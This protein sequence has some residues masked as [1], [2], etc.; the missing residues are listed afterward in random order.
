MDSRMAEQL[1]PKEL[2][3][4]ISGKSEASIEHPDINEDSIAFDE[5]AGF[6][7]VLDGMGGLNAGDEASKTARD[8]IVKRISRIREN[9][10][11]VK[12][13]QEMSMAFGDASVNVRKK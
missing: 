5:K 2:S 10:D 8:V 13:Q 6:A 11:P 7:M 1:P 9:M 3:I 12:A 4:K